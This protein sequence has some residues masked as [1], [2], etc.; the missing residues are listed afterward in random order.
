V[1]LGT[2]V[3]S[4]RRRIKAGKIQA[5]HDQR[6]RLRV[7]ASIPA[8][9]EAASTNLAELWEEV[10]ATRAQLA[11]STF[12]AHELRRDLD[13]AHLHRHEAQQALEDLQT[14]SNDLRDELETAREAL[15]HTQGELAAMWRVM[16]ARQDRAGQGLTS[17]SN[18]NEAFDMA[19]GRNNLNTERSRIQEQI[20]RVRNLSRRRRWP[21]P[22]AS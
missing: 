14:Q 18:G 21:W 15:K 6:G 13:L 4:V 8:G 19:P 12:A 2:S 3:E 1:L 22:Q 7:K 17:L 11:T 9:S 5:F 10:K 20:S 16:S